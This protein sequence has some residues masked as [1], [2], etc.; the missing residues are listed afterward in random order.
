MWNQSQ[1]QT[2]VTNRPWLLWPGPQDCVTTMTLSHNWSRHHNNIQRPT[3]RFVKLVANS[4]YMYIEIFQLYQVMVKQSSSNV[5]KWLG[6]F[7]IGFLQKNKNKK[8]HWMSGLVRTISFEQN[9]FD[10]TVHRLLDGNTVGQ[11]KVKYI[12]AF[13]RAVFLSPGRIWT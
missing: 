3:L 9:H 1:A 7:L 10:T 4:S 12:Q 2:G 5:V 11:R 6:S 13:S 8:I